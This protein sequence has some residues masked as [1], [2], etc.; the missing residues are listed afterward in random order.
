MN[1]VDACLCADFIDVGSEQVLLLCLNDVMNDDCKSIDRY[2]LTDCS[3]YSIDRLGD[4]SSVSLHMMRID[5]VIS[6]F[7]A[8]L[9]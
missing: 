8:Q 7:D 6:S 3:R 4:S 9:Q 2:L 1:N 5:Y